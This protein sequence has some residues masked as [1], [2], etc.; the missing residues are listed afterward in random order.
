MLW[1]LYLIVYWSEPGPTYHGNTN[2]AYLEF[3]RIHATK[4]KHETELC[5]GSLLELYIIKVVCSLYKYTAEVYVVSSHSDTKVMQEHVDLK[6]SHT[7]LEREFSAERALENVGNYEL[8][9]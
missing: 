5:H 3:C 9:Y 2:I 4:S 1:E 7:L 8:E 6:E